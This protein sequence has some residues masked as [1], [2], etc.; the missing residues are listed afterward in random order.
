MAHSTPSTL[1]ADAGR[2]IGYLQRGGTKSNL[3]TFKP[4]R[5]TWYNSGDEPP[6]PPTGTDVYF[7]VSPCAAIPPTNAAGELAPAS[8]IRSQNEY[9]AALNCLYAEFDAKDFGG[10]LDETLAHVRGLAVPPSVI[11]ASGGGYHCFWLLVEPF[12]LDTDKA[13]ERAVD[14][15]H[16]WVA[17]VGGDDGAKDIARVL[18]V[19]GT[20]NYKYSPPRPVTFVEQDYS[21]TYTLDALHAMLP[22]VAPRKARTPK[23][24]AP[25]CQ[26]DA[27]Q[28]GVAQPAIDF[29]AI[30]KAAAALARLRVERRDEYTGWLQVGMALRELGDAG[31]QLWQWWSEA[32][33]KY[34]VGECAEKW[35]TFRIGTP[36]GNDITLASLYRYADEDGEPVSTLEDGERH[37]LENYKARDI[38][39]QR[40][41]AMDAPMW[42]KGHWVGMLPAIEAGHVLVATKDGHTGSVAVDYGNFAAILNT[43]KSRVCDAVTLAEQAGLWRKDAEYKETKGGY[44]VKLI[45][46]DLQPA[47]FNPE[48]AQPL[49]RKL[50]GGKRA[51]AGR[52]P[53]C[54]TCA[55]GTPMRETTETTI[56]TFCMGCGECLDEVTTYKTREL[57]P[58]DAPTVIQDETGYATSA[59]YEPEREPVDAPRYTPGEVWR[60]VW[61]GPDA[62]EPVTVVGLWDASKSPD[63]RAYYQV[64]ES[65]NGMPADEVELLTH[66]DEHADEFKMKLVNARET[67]LVL[68][69]FHLEKTR[70][71][72]VPLALVETYDMPSAIRLADT[73]APVDATECRH[74]KTGLVWTQRGEHAKAAALAANIHD[75]RACAILLHLAERTP[76][77]APGLR[78]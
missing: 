78:E 32:S 47:H 73:Y 14:V 44:E 34:K 59:G 26:T 7:G 13:R 63:G 42:A 62:D 19:P 71:E 45:R 28:P 4:T 11:V 60:A 36:G 57:M 76:A 33:P 39:Q 50:H 68:L 23:P 24:D 5:T 2:F 6:A 75:E 22:A 69:P 53:K 25:A 10:S 56:K 29:M 77:I 52:K 54:A 31:L 35:P 30:S 67:P 55:P 48:L 20:L 65:A 64:R 51:G 9:I 15:Q 74:Y 1:D 66:H 3:Q 46:L 21:R 41:M 58:D 16:R 37:Q 27:L 72:L 40:I 8:A 61:H 18:R 17:F 43:S 49:E 70:D 12:I 38:Q